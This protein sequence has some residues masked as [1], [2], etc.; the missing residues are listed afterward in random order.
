VQVINDSVI[1]AGRIDGASELGI[2]HRIILP[3]IIPGVAVNAIF[4]FV[5]SWNNYILPL[6]ILTT[7]AKKTMP[8]MIAEMASTAWHADFGMIYLAAAVSVLPILI[9]FA[10]L[11]RRILEGVAFGGTKE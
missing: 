4:A 2:F 1:Q 5:G 9:V 8:M 7:D 3:I 6:V 10:S 11:S